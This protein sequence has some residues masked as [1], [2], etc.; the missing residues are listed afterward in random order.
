MSLCWSWEHRAKPLWSWALQVL[1]GQEGPTPDI[2][3][4]AW[5]LRAEAEGSLQGCGHAGEGSA[6]QGEL[7][8]GLMPKLRPK[9]QVGSV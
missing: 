7:S 3:G 4:Q 8:R 1:S 6:I 5:E 2:Q 9:G